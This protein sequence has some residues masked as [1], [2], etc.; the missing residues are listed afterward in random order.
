MCRV[1][2]T[3][4][5]SRTRWLVN[6]VIRGEIS[7]THNWTNTRQ[8]YNER[9]VRV[10]GLKGSHVSPLS[11]CSRTGAASAFVILCKQNKPGAQTSSPT[12]PTSRTCYVCV[13]KLFW[14]VSSVL[15]RRNP[16]ELRVE[17]VLAP[18]LRGTSSSVA[19]SRGCRIKAKGKS[20]THGYQSSSI[21]NVDGSV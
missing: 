19:R 5:N 18:L 14:V 7:S 6:R 10:S 9:Q 8:L 11:G 2:D 21:L 13:K 15:R 4:G 3:K 12:Q 17:C 20:S 16:S 1:C